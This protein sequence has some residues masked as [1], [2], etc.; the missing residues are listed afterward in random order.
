M[1]W[2]DGAMEKSQRGNNGESMT[3]DE[4]IKELKKH[5]GDSKVAWRDHD[6]S[7]NEI[8]DLVRGVEQ[9]DPEKSFDPK[10]CAGVKVLLVS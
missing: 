9:F 3:V 1:P 7:E 8:N 6:Q 4:L 10:F 5:P 2:Q